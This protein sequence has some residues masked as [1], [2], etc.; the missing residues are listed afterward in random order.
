MAAEALDLLKRI[1]ETGMPAPAVEPVAESAADETQ[2]PEGDADVSVHANLFGPEEGIQMNADDL[3]ALVALR[4]IT[5]AGAEAGEEGG[6]W[7]NLS[8]ENVTLANVARGFQCSMAH[9]SRADRMFAASCYATLLST[10][11]CPVCR[12]PCPATSLSASMDRNGLS[13]HA[14]FECRKPGTGQF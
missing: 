5:P 9:G 10:P 6:F 3:A 4:K 1:Q 13:C 7:A 2:L 14:W 12:K 8:K 11:G